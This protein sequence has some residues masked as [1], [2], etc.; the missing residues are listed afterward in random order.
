MSP[1]RPAGRGQSALDGPALP[2]PDVPG[3]AGA[4]GLGKCGAGSVPGALQTHPILSAAW[5][6]VPSAFTHGET[7]ALDAGALPEAPQLVGVGSRADVG[8]K[9]PRGWWLRPGGAEAG[10]GP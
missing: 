1:R 2:P 7:E 6:I 8:R 3:S 5:D 4:A 9:R 10:G